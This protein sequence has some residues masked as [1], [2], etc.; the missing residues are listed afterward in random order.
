MDYSEGTKHT[1]TAVLPSGDIKTAIVDD[2][3]QIN[4]SDLS[5]Y[6]ITE[7]LSWFYL[8]SD[9]PFS[10]F[11]PIYDDMTIITTPEASD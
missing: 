6:D 2:G 1:L 5:L 7:G 11:A 8:E 4:P 9:E 3:I 10:Y